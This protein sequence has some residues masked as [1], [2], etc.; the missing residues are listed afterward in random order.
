MSDFFVQAQE[1]ESGP[2][3]CTVSSSP[4]PARRGGVH[5]SS[6]QL[7]PR[8]T[9]H[10]LSN[11]VVNFLSIPYWF[12]LI[13][14]LKPCCHFVLNLLIEF[15]CEVLGRLWMS[16]LSLQL[17]EWQQAFPK[18]IGS[19]VIRAGD[20]ERPQMSQCLSPCFQI[21]LTW[22]PINPPQPYPNMRGKH[23]SKLYWNAV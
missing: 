17:S 8:P 4:S 5:S 12:C 19:E 16:Y 9:T 3:A 1:S 2:Y 22:S 14:L 11:H 13:K 15:A 7:R 21:H 20:K 23:S 18:C 6:A 10:C